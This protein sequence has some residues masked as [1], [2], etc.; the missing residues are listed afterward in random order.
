MA[1]IS[2]EEHAGL[3][4]Y[5]NT[6]S[7]RG[8]GKFKS[9]HITG[10]P[11]KGE[12]VG[13]M[14]VV[15]EYKQDDTDFVINN[16]DSLRFIMMFMKRFR[17]MT[18]KVGDRDKTVCFSFSGEDGA[19]SSSGRECPPGPERQ[20]GWCNAC[21]FQY[22]FA[23]V[24]L[25]ENN[26]AMKIDNDKGEKEPCFVYFRN[27]GMKFSAAI[28]FLN[29]LDIK[30][31]DLPPL[32]DNE[33]YE[34]NVVLPRRFIIEVKPG[35]KKS[36]QWGDIVVFNYDPIQILPDKAVAK[37]IEDSS[38]FKDDFEKQF[39]VG[40]YIAKPSDAANP[41]AQKEPPEG[42]IAFDKEEVKSESK[43]SSSGEESKPSDV[44]SDDLAGEIDLGF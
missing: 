39:N 5:S 38:K 7:Q 25:D 29:A 10:K 24:L 8:P 13:K 37:I 11:R 23:G 21:K 20:N 35:T 14:Q 33:D 41:D 22:M 31:K 3:N 6:G 28:D 15:R 42:S 27:A 44:T 2:S 16:A 30:G 34:K 32:S 9:V 19:I 17:V 40:K 18:K 43:E 4:D 36:E 26:K 12:T 1:L